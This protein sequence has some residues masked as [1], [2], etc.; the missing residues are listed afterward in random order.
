MAQPVVLVQEF[1]GLS[2]LCITFMAPPSS[3]CVL[4]VGKM[5]LSLHSRL[6]AKI[7][8]NERG[9]ESCERVM[10]GNSDGGKTS[11]GLFSG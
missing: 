11:D 1:Q 2:G 8:S 5:R 7:V 10:S 6:V 4:L 3:F 9:R